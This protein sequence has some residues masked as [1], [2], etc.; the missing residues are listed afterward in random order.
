LDTSVLEPF[1][2]QYFAKVLP[3]WNNKTYKM[4]EYLLVNL[5]PLALANKTLA[6][7]TE[8]F[9]KNPELASKPALKRIIVENL[10]NVQRALESQATDSRS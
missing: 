3:V 2:D 10:A 9:L 5:Y 6:D 4:A 7:Q 1:V 8:K